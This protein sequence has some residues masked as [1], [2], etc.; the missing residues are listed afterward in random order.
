MAYFLNEKDMKNGNNVHPFNQIILFYLC[1]SDD[2]EAVRAVCDSITHN[3]FP[4][5]NLEPVKSGKLLFKLWFSPYSRVNIVRRIENYASR[6][7]S[8]G[9]T[10]SVA[11]LVHWLPFVGV[12][13]WNRVNDRLSGEWIVV[14]ACYSDRPQE[15]IIDHIS[16]GLY[17][18]PRISLDIYIAPLSVDQLH[19]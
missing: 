1:N 3:N 13:I 5:F 16:I 19:A 9:C 7:P 11:A 14:Q 12:I 6:G 15:F 2:L 8:V 10:A 4:E 17:R 18:L